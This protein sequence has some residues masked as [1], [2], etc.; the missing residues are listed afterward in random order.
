[1]KGIT[2]FR[3]S[4]MMMMMVKR[5]IEDHHHGLCKGAAMFYVG[6]ERSDRKELLERIGVYSSPSVPLVAFQSDVPEKGVFLG[7]L[8]GDLGCERDFMIRGFAEDDCRR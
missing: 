8:G 2:I 1:M 6:K 7:K 5:G 3:S 4:V